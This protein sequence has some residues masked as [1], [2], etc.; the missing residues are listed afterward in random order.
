MVRCS[1]PDLG[2]REGN[3]NERRRASSLHGSGCAGRRVRV[4]GLESPQRGPQSDPRTNVLCRVW[5]R[6]PGQE[7]WALVARRAAEE[8]ENRARTGSSRG[9]TA[10]ATLCSLLPGR[11]SD[12]RPLYPPVRHP[13][14]CDVT[15]PSGQSPGGFLRRAQRASCGALLAFSLQSRP[16]PLPA[17]SLRPWGAGRCLRGPVGGG[18][19]R[20]AMV[21]LTLPGS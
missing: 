14:L 10:I 1:G 19:P 2:L 11:P 17:W 6:G 20:V 5:A 8:A 4:R 18:R 7:E 16:A 13:P 15:C 12:A 3:T 9:N 21:T